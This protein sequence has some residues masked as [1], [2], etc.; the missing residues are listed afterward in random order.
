MEKLVA[1]QTQETGLKMHKI[2]SQTE[3]FKTFNENNSKTDEFWE[4]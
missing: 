4:F 2:G 3:I 1:N